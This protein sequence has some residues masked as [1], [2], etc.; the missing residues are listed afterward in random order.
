M[1]KHD[2]S[3]RYRLNQT[4]MRLPVDMDQQEYNE[5]TQE[6]L[7]ELQA[8]SD[9]EAA[10]EAANER[11]KAVKASGNELIKQ[12]SS[13]IESL[14]IRLQHN[15]VMGDVPVVEI[16][17]YET[18]TVHVRRT[19]NN[20]IVPGKFRRMTDE[21]IANGPDLFQEVISPAQRKLLPSSDEL[22]HEKD[23][24]SA[25]AVEFEIL[26]NEPVPDPISEHVP[27]TVQASDDPAHAKEIPS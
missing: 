6:L 26:D 14:R 18:G 10:T 24:A 3:H 1:T 27:D 21:E 8:V 12:A 16:F 13:R 4:T 23:S 22:Q 19:D 7:A 2:D 5:T 17:D 20:D 15:W 11:Y 25:Q 9:A